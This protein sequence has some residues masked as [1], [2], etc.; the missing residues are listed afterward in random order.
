MN[1]SS[2]HRHIFLVTNYF[3]GIDYKVVIKNLMYYMRV[4]LGLKS[5]INYD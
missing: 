5:N 3:P 4:D 1:E 2:L